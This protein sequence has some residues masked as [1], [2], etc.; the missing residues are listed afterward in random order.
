MLHVVRAQAQ[1]TTLFELG[2]DEPIK[3]YPG[4]VQ[5]AR[6]VKVQAPGKH[7]NNLT[8]AEAAAHG[9]RLSRALCCSPAS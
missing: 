1:T 4:Q 5:V 7:F 8:G 6:A 3:Q 2:V 9:R